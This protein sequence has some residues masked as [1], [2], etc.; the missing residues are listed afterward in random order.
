[1]FSLNDMWMNVFKGGVDT[2]IL[3][4]LSYKEK[5]GYSTFKTDWVLVICAKIVGL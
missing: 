3:I 5:Y 4:M 1:M 2:S